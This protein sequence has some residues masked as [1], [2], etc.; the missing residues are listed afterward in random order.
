MPRAPILLP[1]V[2]GLL[3]TACGDSRPFGAAR[4]P[5][6]D[7]QATAPCA[8]PEDM[9]GAGDWEVIAGRIGLALIRCGQEKQL[10]AAWAAG[11]L[12]ATGKD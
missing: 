11:V 6:P 1:L 12:E 5:P 3:L 9:L 2:G 10:L 7:A 8:R 4:V